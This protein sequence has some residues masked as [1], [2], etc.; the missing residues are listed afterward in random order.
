V[1]EQAA[2]A[3]NWWRVLLVDA[4]LGV[5][6]AAVGLWRGGAFLVL[7]ALGAAYVVAIAVRALRWR[8]LRRARPPDQGR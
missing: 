1:P 6:A 7:A 5:A 8:R 4:L 2:Y 3:S